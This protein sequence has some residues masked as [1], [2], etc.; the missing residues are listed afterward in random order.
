M[1]LKSRGSDQIMKTPSNPENFVDAPNHGTSGKGRSASC[2]PFPWPMARRKREE[3][4]EL[5][6]L[7][8][9]FTGWWPAK[10]QTIGLGCPASAFTLIELLVV[11][12]IIAI[13]AGLLLPAL[14][15]AKAK[16]QS[17]VCSNNLKQLQLAWQIGRSMRTITR[18]ECHP[19]LLHRM[20]CS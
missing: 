15:K 13:L 9:L 14:G 2:P 16:G 7:F 1:N 6:R 17:A 12:A 5:S 11:I 8:T 3:K 20:V 18:I 19:T 10:L 4:L